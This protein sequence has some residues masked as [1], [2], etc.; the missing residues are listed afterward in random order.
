MLL[1]N[2]RVWVFL[3]EES[4]KAERLGKE[5]SAIDKLLRVNARKFTAFAYIFGSEKIFRENSYISNTI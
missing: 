2:L 5:D 1:L 4:T 3:N